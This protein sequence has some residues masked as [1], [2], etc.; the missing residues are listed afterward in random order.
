MK[1]WRD[2][3][4]GSEHY[5]IYYEGGK[6]RVTQRMSGWLD[7]L[8]RLATLNPAVDLTTFPAVLADALPNRG[9]HAS[10]E[11]APIGRFVRG[12]LFPL[13]VICALVWLAIQTTSSQ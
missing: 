7:F 8:T 1:Y 11:R 13:I 12:A 6:L 10:E 9:G 4:N 3:E 2:S 5:T